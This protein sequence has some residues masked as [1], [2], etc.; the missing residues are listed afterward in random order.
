MRTFT[1]PAR[2]IE[3]CPFP[4]GESVHLSLMAELPTQEEIKHLQ[5]FQIVEDEYQI[6][7]KEIYLYFR[8]SIRNFKLAVRLQKLDVHSTL[9]NWKTVN[10]F[11]MQRI[12]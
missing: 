11:W 12:R 9:R 8:Q 2:I 7:G 3:K 5:K 1:E 4:D 6:E 10:R